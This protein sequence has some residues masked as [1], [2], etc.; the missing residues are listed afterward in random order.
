[1]EYLSPTDFEGYSRQT[2]QVLD[3]RQSPL[4]KTKAVIMCCLITAVINETKT[5]CDNTKNPVLEK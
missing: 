3:Q 4:I 1:M 2:S 5:K